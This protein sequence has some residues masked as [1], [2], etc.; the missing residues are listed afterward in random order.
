MTTRPTR[1]DRLEA[2]LFRA[3]L[4]VLR[5]IGPVAASNVS[6]AIT[7]TIGPLIPVSRVA[8]ANLRRAMPELDAA[9]RRRVVRGAWDNFGRVFGELP[10]VASFDETPS[11]PGYELVG[12]EHAQALLARGGSVI[13]VSGHIA[14]WEVLANA[15]ARNGLAFASFYRAPANPLVDDIITELRAPI[16]AGVAF[17]KGAIGARGALAYLT[18]GGH[19]GML[20]DQKMNDGIEARFF[21]LPAM[22]APAA[23]AYGLRFR[24]P[25][26][27]AYVQRLGPARFRVICEKPL[28]PVDT[29][30]RRADMAALTQAINDRLEAWIRDR[31]AE[32]LWLHRRWPKETP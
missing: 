29:G 27:P 21:G 28:E 26:V 13:F 14:N 2:A 11:G 32:W 5:A 7:R 12:R 3:V 6:G 30:D 4:A 10:H 16:S 23:A 22:T 9:A 31:P 18:K 19:L 25:I 17:R 15:A 8:D 1:L 24:C 20:V